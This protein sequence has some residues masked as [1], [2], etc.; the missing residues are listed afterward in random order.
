MQ[1]WQT[2]QYLTHLTGA[3]LVRTQLR[4][5]NNKAS[6]EVVGRLPLLSHWQI[7]MPLPT[8]RTRSSFPMSTYAIARGMHSVPPICPRAVQCNATL[9]RTQS[10]ACARPVVL[11]S[12][13]RGSSK[14]T[15]HR[16]PQ[17]IRTRTLRLL[18]QSRRCHCVRHHAEPYGVRRQI[19]LGLC[20]STSTV[21]TT[22]SHRTLSDRLVRFLIIHN[23]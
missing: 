20:V 14:S 12:S 4:L 18:G 15:V 21:A 17:L 6:V 10:M 5:H 11:A 7:G 2:L 22:R 19:R 13:V 3:I 16:P 8:T 1:I 23:T 9:P